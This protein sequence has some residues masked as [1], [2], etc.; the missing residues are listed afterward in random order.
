[1]DNDKKCK[2]CEEIIPKIT[3]YQLNQIAVSQGYCSW[4]CLVSSMDSTTIAAL[5]KKE[6][7]KEMQ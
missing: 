4:S 7:E 5:I 2:L 3:I 1:M 6:R